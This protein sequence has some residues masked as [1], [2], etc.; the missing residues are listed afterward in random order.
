[1]KEIMTRNNTG[2]NKRISKRKKDA[3]KMNDKASSCRPE[4]MLR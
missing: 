3:D 4:V 2:I 1:M